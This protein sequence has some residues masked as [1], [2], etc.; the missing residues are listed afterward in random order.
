MPPLPRPQGQLEAQYRDHA[1]PSPEVLFPSSFPDQLYV[2]ASRILCEESVSKHVD[3][4]HSDRTAD[5]TEGE[6]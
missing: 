2:E 5:W 4:V 6:D 3:I 1:Y